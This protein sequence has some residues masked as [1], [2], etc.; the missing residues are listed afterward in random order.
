MI[1]SFDA[2][3]CEGATLAD[4]SSDNIRRFVSVARG[5]GFPLAEDAA[6][7]A[8]LDRLGLA[9]QGRPSH[10]AV[11]LFGHEPQRFLSSSGIRCT[12]F[13]GTVA[14][15]PIA[16][17]QV[18]EGT[19]FESMDQAMYFVLSRI[20]GPAPYELPLEAV[21]EAIGNAVA[22]RNY[23][24]S[25][26]VLVTLFSDR[27]EVW[28][29]GELPPSLTLAHLRQAH[30]SLPANPLLAEALYLTTYRAAKGTGT[31]DMIE[32]CRKAGLPEPEFKLEDRG[33]M[34][35]LRRAKAP[36]PAPVGDEDEGQTAPPASPPTAPP[37]TPRPSVD[38]QVLALV[39]L[40]GKAG[41]LGTAEIIKR[42]GLKSR[43]DLHERFLR[44]ALAASL[45]EP[46]IPDKPNSRL[47]QYRLT[48]K[49]AALAASL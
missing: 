1:E 2:A 9:P 18:C 14:E 38:P 43:S 26:S 41:A 27:L 35:I 21:R 17:Q 3:P 44:P 16:S 46:T 19:V 40:L 48:A 25:A 42:L 29:V 7:Q 4:L 11:L 33:F 30:S 24:V 31:C 22:H 47:Q 12:Q 15:K 13:E 39:R 20:S 45:I 10:A 32:L 23:A 8:V 37:A 49:G 34:A 5:R 28:N 36:V 6:P